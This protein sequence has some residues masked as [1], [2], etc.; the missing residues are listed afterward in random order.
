MKRPRLMLS[1]DDNIIIG[2]MGFMVKGEG[3]K[4]GQGEISL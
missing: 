1:A 2:E 3:I 4:G